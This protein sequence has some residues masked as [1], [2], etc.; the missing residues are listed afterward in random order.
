MAFFKISESAIWVVPAPKLTVV[1]KCFN[2]L[3][4]EQFSLVICFSTITHGFCK[5]FNC[6]RLA[7]SGL[8]LA[9]DS[10]TKLISSIL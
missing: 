1:H 8:R 5:R 3:L 2:F 6:Y 7:I 9:T 4:S 10:Q